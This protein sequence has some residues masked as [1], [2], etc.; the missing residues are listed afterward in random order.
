MIAT[1]STTTPT[2]GGRARKLYSNLVPIERIPIPVP[3]SIFSIFWIFKFDESEWALSPLVKINFYDFAIF[4]EDVFQ[5]S[6]LYIRRQIADVNFAVVISKIAKT[7]THILLIL[8]VNRVAND[9]LRMRRIVR[10][11]MVA[12]HNGSGVIIRV[13][14]S[15]L[16]AKF[17]H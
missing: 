5:I 16:Q 15:I 9:L 3:H 8:H 1:T 4:V 13:I 14:L 10:M 17:T 6:S 11:R 12:V 7:T 2:S